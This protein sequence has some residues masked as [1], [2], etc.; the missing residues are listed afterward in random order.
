MQ[1][2]MIPIKAR[3]ILNDRETE[4]MFC[5]I[6]QIIAA[7]QQ[8]LKVVEEELHGDEADVISIIK[9]MVRLKFYNKEL[10]TELIFGFSWRIWTFLE[11]T[12]ETYPKQCHY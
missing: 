5:N 1:L 10:R 8:A 7:E 12:A 9:G 11:R 2:Y 6:R 3:K 4:E